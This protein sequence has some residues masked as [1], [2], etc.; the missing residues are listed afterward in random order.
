MIQYL[1]Y[2]I[3]NYRFFSCHLN[4]DSM[5]VIRQLK[6][7]TSSFSVKNEKPK[8][9]NSKMLLNEGHCFSK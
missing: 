6:S 3:L 1:N 4:I 8:N 5:C 2:K 9:N 7:L